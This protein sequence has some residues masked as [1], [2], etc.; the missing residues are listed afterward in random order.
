[1]DDEDDEDDGK[2]LI[3]EN[4]GKELTFYESKFSRLIDDGSGKEYSTL[5][6]EK[7]RW[8]IEID[9]TKKKEDQ[10]ATTSIIGCSLLT[11]KS[12][13]GEKEEVFL[14]GYDAGGGKH[15]PETSSNTIKIYRVDLENEKLIF[16]K[17][18]VVSPG[19]SPCSFRWGKGMNIVSSDRVDVFTTDKSY[20]SIFNLRQ[21]KG[22]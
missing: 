9:T 19:T 17:E 13:N 1:M 2:Y 4:S 18:K 22:I 10:E 14:L 12:K 21:W 20:G 7:F 16:L 3:A 5:F 11:Q 15:D 6:I 8:K